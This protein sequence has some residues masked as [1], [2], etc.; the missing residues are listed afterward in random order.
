MLHVIFALLL[1]TGARFDT[2][3]YDFQRRYHD[4][5][6]VYEI[7]RDQINFLKDVKARAEWYKKEAL[8]DSL[9]ACA[10][11]RLSGYNGV[12]Y[13][14]DS[15]FNREG[16]GTAWS[17]P[18]PAADEPPKF[19]VFRTQTMFITGPDGRTI[20]PYIIVDYYSRHGKL[21]HS[22]KADPITFVEF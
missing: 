9:A 18:K 3:G 12:L 15:E 21:M 10:I 2:T 5:L 14:P 16:Y 6:Y 17:Y 22:A 19:R 8:A 4:S 11:R 7:Y 20:T 1:G 13:A